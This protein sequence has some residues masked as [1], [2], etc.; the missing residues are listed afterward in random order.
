MKLPSLCAS[1]RYGASFGA[2][3]PVLQVV[4]HLLDD[5]ERDALLRFFGRGAEVGREDDAVELE[6]RVLRGHRLLDEDVE[7]DAAELAALEAAD[8]RP[9]VV[10]AAARAVHEQDALLH[11]RDRVVVHDA[12]RLVRERRVR[13][14]RVGT[15]EELIDAHELD[16]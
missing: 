1:A 9:F 2:D 7:R 6:Q 14:D 12:A 15:P 16:A 4:D 3:G 10:H 5:L 13:R 11:L 8:E